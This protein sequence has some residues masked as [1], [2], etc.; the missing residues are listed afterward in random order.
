MAHIL[1]IGIR[2]RTFPRLGS[3]ASSR[4]RYDPESFSGEKKQENPNEYV[5]IN[6]PKKEDF[7]DRSWRLRIA[8]L[9]WV[10]GI[11]FLIAMT[12]PSPTPTPAPGPGAA[13]RWTNY[14]ELWN[15]TDTK[16]YKWLVV[17][18]QPKGVTNI[19]SGLDTS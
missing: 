4:I 18:C 12:H 6:S 1:R 7:F 2:R 3:S 14:P 13:V 8:S 17:E 5:W 11:M 19:P 9:L 15:S 10:I 16:V